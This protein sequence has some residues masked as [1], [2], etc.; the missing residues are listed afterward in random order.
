MTLQIGERV[1]DATLAIMGESGPRSV[2]S[3]ELFRGR[4]VVLFGLPGAFTPTCSALHLPGFLAAADSFRAKGIDV[5]ACL[6]V[7]DVFVMDAWGKEQKVGEK[8]LMLADGNGDFTRAAGLDLDMRHRGF[9]I[10]SQRFA[11]IL[12]DGVVTALHVEKPGEF[13]VSDAQTMLGLL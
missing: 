8:V 2:T 13:Q 12:E 9:G 3:G 6:A 1:P 11:M 7:N 4:R 5:I 10:R